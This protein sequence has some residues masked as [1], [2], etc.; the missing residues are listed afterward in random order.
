MVNYPGLEVNFTRIAEYKHT[1]NQPAS[2]L[3]PANPWT[4]IV[5]EYSTD[6]GDPY[7]PVPNQ[8]N[9]EL[10]EKYQKLAE[11]EK[12]VAFVGRL[13]SYKYFNMDQAVLNALELFDSLQYH[14]TIGYWHNWV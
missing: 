2:A 9:H 13:A 6:K 10:Y 11:A 8:K 14:G 5:R 4:V 1:P 12:G 7:Y 3:S